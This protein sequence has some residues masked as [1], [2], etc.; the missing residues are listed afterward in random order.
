[1]PEGSR[2]IGFRLG[3]RAITYRLEGGHVAVEDGVAD[4][5]TV[6]VM[7]DRDWDAVLKQTRTFVNLHLAGDL[8]FERGGFDGLVEWDPILKEMH[9]GIPVYDPA[10]VDLSGLDVSRTFTLLDADDEIR[11]FLAT[12]GFAHLK[13]V[14]TPEEIA[15]LN[16]EVDRLAAQAVPGDDRSW[17]VT[18]ADTN[19]Q[20]CRLVYAGLSS[21]L[22]ARFE[23][24]PRVA[25]LGRLLYPDLQVAGD[26][27][28]GTSVL[29]KVPGRT[30]GL[31]NIPWHQ[32]CGMGG[33]A[34]CCPSIAVGIQLTGSSAATGNLLILPGSHG[35]SVHYDWPH[36]Y[37]GAPVVEV[38]TDPGDVTVHVADVMHASPQPTGPGGRRTMYVTFYRPD[39]WEHVGQGQASNDLIRARAAEADALQRPGGGASN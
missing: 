17:W 7:A 1:M 19:E 37:P 32:D 34:I 12:T 3:Q 4:A 23:A 5:T 31:S 25:R 13:A 27:M 29:L 36:R 24:D 10:R 18:D 38:D 16:D 21:P 35:Q 28:E 33:H 30:V 8:S 14:F 39:L 26:R 9:C 2:S 22:I 15:R 6:V 20:L 11:A